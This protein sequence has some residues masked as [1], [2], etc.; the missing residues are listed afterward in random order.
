MPKKRKKP[1]PKTAKAKL[2]ADAAIACW[3]DDPGD[4]DSQPG[5]TPIS[6][7]VPDPS[8]GSLP[9]KISGTAPEPKI[10]RQGTPEFLY[11]AAA[12]ALRRTSD[13]WAPILPKGT[14]WQV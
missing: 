10:Y 1:A 11:Y 2:A 4:P 3:E 7:P 8:A 6:E 5:L 9:F 13:F 14:T 12:C